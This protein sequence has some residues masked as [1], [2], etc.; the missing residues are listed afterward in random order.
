MQAFR[1]FLLWLA[2]PTLLFWLIPALIVLITVGTVA[3]K[4][5][6]LYVAEKTFF[7]SVVF[8]A[9]GWLPLPGG[10]L[11]MGLFTLSLLA[12]FLMKS[13]WTRRR[14]GINLSHFS[15][16][17]LMAGGLF[18]SLTA[19]DGFLTVAEGARS[20]QVQD[21][22]QRALMLVEGKNLIATLDPATLRVGQVLT[23]PDQPFKLEVLAIC[24]NCAISERS[25]DNPELR[26]MAR[27]MALSPTKLDLKDEANVGG[28][29]FRLSE[30][31][32]AQN[33]IHIIFED[34]PT[35]KINTGV[36][37]LELIYGKQQRTLPFTVELQDFVKT[38]YP[39]TDS[40]KAY[41]SDII[42]HDGALSWPA[43]IEMNKPLRYRGYTLYQSAFMQTPEQEFTVLAVSHDS[44]QFLPYL[45]TFLLALGLLL[46]LWLRREEAP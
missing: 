3:Q 6:G 20:A 37:Q 30:L 45:G 15:V 13:E 36:R 18:S 32:E 43:R 19:E 44:G 8:F 17:L 29:T 14:A 12:K 7:H 27:G 11:L 2:G 5:V 42:I 4:Y 40:A 34:G 39:G 31:D 35:T 23:Y 16:I 46:H 21:Y 41:H 10:Y 25:D 26:S 9:G 24:R 1:S 33:G 28:L 38:T 22:H